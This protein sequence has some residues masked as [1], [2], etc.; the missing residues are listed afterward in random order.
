MLALSKPLV[1]ATDHFAIGQGIQ[2]SLLGD[3][4]LGTSRSR[5]HMPELANGVACPL[6]SLLLENMLGRAAMLDLVVGCRKLNAE[7]A[8]ELRLIDEMVEEP[9]RLEA[10]ALDRLRSLVHYPQT[11]FR[12]T[13][14]IHNRRLIDLLGSVRED[15]V[16]AHTQTFLSGSAKA[17]FSRILGEQT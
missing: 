1:C 6:G 17:H 8:L 16:H 15:A 11:P 10:V 4:R 3:R 7:Q 12:A 13:K 5:Y 2:V 14:R 9:R